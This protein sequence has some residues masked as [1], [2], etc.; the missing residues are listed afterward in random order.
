[1]KII[2]AIDLGYGRVKLTKNVDE[3][4]AVETY[5][6]PSICTI[7]SA[8]SISNGVLNERKTINVIQNDVTYEVGQDAHLNA[9]AHTKRVLNDKYIQSNEYFALMKG[10]LKLMD[11]DQID[12]LVLGTP[13]S[14][15]EKTKSVLKKNWTGEIAI[16]DQNSILIKQV[17]VYPQPLGGLVHFCSE[18]NQ[19]TDFMFK[20]NLVIDPGYYTLDW[21]ITE[22]MK[23]VK[24]S[25]S[26]E[27]GMNFFIKAIADAFGTNSNNLITCKKIDN[28]FTQNEPFLFGGS[29]FDLN[30]YLPFAHSVVDNAISQML[31][32]ITEVDNIE[33]IILVGGAAGIYLPILN[34]HFKGRVLNMSREVRYANLLGF[35]QIGKTI[36]TNK[37]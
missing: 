3:N 25:G 1:M 10:A 6:F 2:R 32:E 34:K 8:K 33:N 11:V 18:T 23:S 27:G 30:I 37:K 14:N 20:R 28:F 13:V 7:Q 4:G 29:D 21:L 31:N 35:Y 22:D 5:S 19:Q 36:I 26:C 9:D 16:D 15:Y 24:G 17:K 12:V